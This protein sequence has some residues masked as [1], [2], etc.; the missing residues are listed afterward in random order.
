MQLEIKALCKVSYQNL[1]TMFEL[2]FTNTH[3]DLVLQF[4]VRQTPIAAKW[5]KEIQQNYDLF[6]TERLDHWGLDSKILI[7]KLNREI[8]SINLFDYVIDLK[9][10][11]NY[12]QDQ[13]N[14]LHKFFEDLRGEITEGTVWYNTAPDYVKSALTNYN[15]Y[16]HQL[17]F[18]LRVPV[19][20]PTAVVTFRDRPRYE[21][22]QDDMQHFTYCWQSGTVYINYCHVGKTILDAYNDNDILVEAIRPQTHYSA[23]FMVKFGPSMPQVLYNEKSKVLDKWIKDK[24][25]QFPNLNLGMI[26]VADLKTPVSYDSL[27]KFN[28]VKSVK[29]NQNI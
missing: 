27:F 10:D 16:I 11:E 26:P 8:D 17:E 1:K 25:L 12:S 6:E 14:Y 3:E 18:L 20:S 13:L 28:K 5:F 21:L 23:D 7:E 24:N 15:V 19:L 9:L 4:E 29:V 22:T 2:V